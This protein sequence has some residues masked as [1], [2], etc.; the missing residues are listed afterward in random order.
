[1]SK[2]IIHEGARKREDEFFAKMEFERKRK[3]FEEEHHKMKQEAKRKL[4]DEH[5]MHC[6]K[7]GM[8]MVELDFEGIKIDKCSECLGIYLDNGELETLLE[9]KN[10]GLIG[11]FA[12]M[13]K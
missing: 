1:M 11:R 6:P 3:I 2:E 13:F 5:W 12:R 4:K 8:E 10:E 9:K 7:C